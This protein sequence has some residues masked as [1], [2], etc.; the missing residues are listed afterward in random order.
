VY[1]GHA[2]SG[3]DGKALVDVRMR[4]EPFLQETCPFK[5]RPKPNGSVKWVTPQLVC[6]VVFSCWTRDG[7][8]R[9]PVFRGLTSDVLATSVRR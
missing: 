5:R 6:E 4:L 2:G 8:L 9:H 1:I 7:H 3:F